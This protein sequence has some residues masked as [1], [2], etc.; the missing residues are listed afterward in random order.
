MAAQRGRTGGHVSIAAGRARTAPGGLFE[1]PFRFAALGL[2]AALLGGG[3]AELVRDQWFAVDQHA[4]RHVEHRLQDRVRPTRRIR[5]RKCSSK[6]VTQRESQS[7][8]LAGH[9]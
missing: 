3:E 6:V 4:G 1:P 9:L 5:E 7:R 2:G 8:S